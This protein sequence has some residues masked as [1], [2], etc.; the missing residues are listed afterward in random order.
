MIKDLFTKSDR[1]RFE[2]IT[3]E[4]AVQA[5]AWYWRSKQFAIDFT[6]PYSLRGQRYF[7]KLGL[8]QW[9]DA[10]C[11]DEGGGSAIS[12]S[13]SA[14]LTDEGAV[15]GAVGAVLILPVTAVVGAVSYVEYENDAQRLMNEFWAYVHDFH[16]SQQ[17]PPQE[18]F[19]PWAQAQQGPVPAPLAC[20]KCGKSLDPDSAFCKYCGAGLKG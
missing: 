2:G 13:F 1:R 17:P 4:E 20:P 10:H 15:L 8:R 5:T 3:K 7:S 9:V 12:L 16:K 19:P 18:S 14:E 11:T 6:S